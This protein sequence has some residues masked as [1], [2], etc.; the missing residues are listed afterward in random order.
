[1]RRRLGDPA[2]PSLSSNFFHVKHFHP[3]SLES[4]RPVAAG[5]LLPAGDFCGLELRNGSQAV[6][7]LFAPSGRVA[8]G[9]ITRR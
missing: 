8:G 1:M 9:G 7:S 6:F 2:L 4:A 5:S 3:K